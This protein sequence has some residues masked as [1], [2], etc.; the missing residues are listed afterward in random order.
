MIVRSPEAMSISEFSG[1]PQ[2]PVESWRT[3]RPHRLQ[4]RFWGLSVVT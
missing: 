4:F 2:F 1:Q 3:E